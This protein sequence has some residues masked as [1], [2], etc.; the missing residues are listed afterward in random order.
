MSVLSRAGLR[1]RL[2]LALIAVAVGSVALATILVNRGLTARLDDYARDRLR[3]S[4]GH[5]AEL[6]AGY[7][8]RDRG[9]SREGLTELDHAA[10]ASGLR[11]S[12]R[13]RTGRALGGSP[14][15][16]GEQ[17][18]ASVIVARRR[19]GAIVAEPVAG[20]ALA[21]EESTLHARLD[22]LHLLAAVLAAV[23]ASAIAVLVAASLARPL[24]R[25]TAV[26]GRMERGELDARAQPG[27]G[28]EITRLG[29]ALDRLAVTLRRQED[30]R[31]QTGADI[32]HELRTPLTG[33]LSR[34][35]AARDGVLPDRG[36]NLEAMHGETLR[37]TA[38][39]EDL[40][41]L[42]DAERPGLLVEKSR[43]DLAAVT[44]R[45]ADGFT[46]RFEA[47]ALTLVRELAPATAWG[48]ERRIEQIVDNLLS[49]AL[50]YTDG[51]GRVTL[52]TATAGAEARLEVQDTGIGI[53]EGDLAHVF[54]R[55]W[56]GEKSRSRATG[57]SGIG[58]A[59]VRELVTAHDGRI[60]VQS[61]VGTG[62]TV[63]VVIPGGPSG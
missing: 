60:D 41:R 61:V 24:R 47:K 48:D 59:I 15:D 38:L 40:E 17:A 44:A 8:A 6:A 51:G 7:Y 35:D 39:V 10:Q 53:A 22:D 28:P 21:A 49:N 57:G 30:L 11:I 62:T 56:R 25:L 2:A 36:A 19:V 31:R 46:G 29:H 33:L 45:R 54:E 34:I 20:S 42:A 52:R 26:A 43:V 3:A 32:A 1:T 50:R 23:L 13:D 9:W 18:S 37:L 63:G 55:F 12:V 27:G 5:V 16:G 58:L 14:L 4:A